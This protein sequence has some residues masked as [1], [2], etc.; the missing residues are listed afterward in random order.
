M[1]LD[2]LAAVGIAAAAALSVWPI[3]FGLLARALPIRAAQLRSAW[4]AH[5][6]VDL[7]G[8]SSALVRGK[9][10]DHP[11]SFWTNYPDANR[12]L[13]S[14]TLRD[15]PGGWITEA[16]RLAV[17]GAGL[18]TFSLVA[19]ILFFRFSDELQGWIMLVASGAITLAALA[20]VLC[21]LASRRWVL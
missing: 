6:W 1:A 11:T 4:S 20:L 2:F 9:R 17:A 12:K 8:F 21:L 16:R 18:Q 7:D 14:K 5:E 3:L 10:L 15:T 13:I 19:S